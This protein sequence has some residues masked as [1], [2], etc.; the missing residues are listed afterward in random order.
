MMQPMIAALQKTRG[1][2]PAPVEEEAEAPAEGGGDALLELL[3][4]VNAKLDKILAALNVGADAAEAPG[5]T[6]VPEGKEAIPN[7]DGY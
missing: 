2:G 5:K 1:E 4:S 7:D 3:M 6:P